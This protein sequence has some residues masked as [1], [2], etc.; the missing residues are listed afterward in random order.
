M[1]TLP[2]SKED[3]SLESLHKAVDIPRR[4]ALCGTHPAAQ[5]QHLQYLTHLKSGKVATGNPQKRPRQAR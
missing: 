1:P 4:W 3:D 5:D 2:F